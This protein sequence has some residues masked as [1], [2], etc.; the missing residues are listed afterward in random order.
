MADFYQNLEHAVCTIARGLSVICF[1]S[2]IRVEE[3]G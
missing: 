1:A 3:D 2:N